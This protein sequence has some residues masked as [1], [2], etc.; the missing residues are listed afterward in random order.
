MLQISHEQMSGLLF[1]REMGKLD[2]F[3]T[4]VM[5]SSLCTYFVYISEEKL[6][7]STWTLYLLNFFFLCYSSDY[8]V[9][10][11]FFLSVYKMLK[12]PRSNFPDL[13]HFWSLFH[14][15]SLWCWT[16]LWSGSFHFLSSCSSL[17]SCKSQWCLFSFLLHGAQGPSWD[18]FPSWC[19][20]LFPCL[21]L[22]RPL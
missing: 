6:Y 22:L 18:A 4:D 17:P 13:V 15:S 7:A 14:S 16:C 11:G 9:S 12:L 8:F 10:T 5:V 3:T 19:P 21:V 2:E 20:Q 1:L